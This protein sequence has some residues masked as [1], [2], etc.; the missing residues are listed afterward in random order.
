MERQVS[1]GSK[2]LS[3]GLPLMLSGLVIGMSTTSASAYLDAGTGSIILQVLL[4]GVAGLAI[5]GKLYWHRFL[6]FLRIRKPDAAE[7]KP[8]PQPDARI[9]S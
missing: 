6:T 2:H 1:M 3:R 4:G 8:G 9:G 5:A 7:M